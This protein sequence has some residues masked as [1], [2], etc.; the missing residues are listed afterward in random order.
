MSTFAKFATT[1]SGGYVLL[2]GA[3]V[4]AAY[5]LYHLLKQAGKDVKEEVGQ[6]ISG[7]TEVVGG[8][9]T[10]RNAVTADTPYYDAGV[11]G[12]LGAAA[13]EISGGGLQSIGEWLGGKIFDFSHSEESNSLQ[14]ATGNPYSPTG[15]SSQYREAANNS[16][17]NAQYAAS[18]L[19]IG[20]INGGGFW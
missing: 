3:G 11:F 12:T 14:S 1:K 8:I 10:G 17:V 18:P 2:I 6:A 9:A 20:V 4:G 16:P 13:N 15:P 19:T 5:L 7:A